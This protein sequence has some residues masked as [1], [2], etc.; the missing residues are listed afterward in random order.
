[1]RSRGGQKVDKS[2][3]VT[4]RW[5]SSDEKELEMEWELGQSDEVLNNGSGKW[6]KESLLPFPLAQF[7]LSVLIKSTSVTALFPFPF[8]PGL[9]SWG[10]RLPAPG[11][12]HFFTPKDQGWANL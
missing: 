9:I 2:G 4:L 7:H 5:E 3:P 11:H 1:M 8:H 10:S 6:G 12:P